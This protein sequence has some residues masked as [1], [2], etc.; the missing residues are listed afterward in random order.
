MAISDRETSQI[1]P[2]RLVRSGGF[3]WKRFQEGGV[4]NI[5]L[6]CA[7]ICVVTTVG[8]LWVLFSQSAPFFANV[9]WAEFLTGTKWTPNNQPPSYGILPLVAGTLLIT[10]GAG[11]IAIPIGLLAAIFLSEYAP[12]KVRAILKPILELLAGIPSVVFGYFALFTVTPYLRSI[13]PNVMQY[14][15]ASA[16][17]VVGIMILPLVSSLCED[18]LGAVPKALREGA[19]GLGA[20]KLEVCTRIVVPAALSGVMASF[21]LA[22]SR[23]LGETMAVTLAAGST[24]TM[25]LDPSKSV[26]TM[27]AYIVSAAR[28][29]AAFGSVRYNSIFAVGVALFLFTMAM[30]LLAARLVKRFRQVYS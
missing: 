25:T 6:L 27:T 28:G 23:A 5:C 12:A 7:T 16:A 24:P 3:D 22:L 21:I 9:P 4:R 18:A 1:L 15:A 30:N 20:T 19:Y 13:F 26:Y 8:I 2:S 11:I 14:N 29:D 17:I 10:L